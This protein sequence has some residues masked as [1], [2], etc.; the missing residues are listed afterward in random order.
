MS[1]E[2]FELGRE[3]A[4]REISETHSLGFMIFKS[5]P[6]AVATIEEHHTEERDAIQRLQNLIEQEDGYHYSLDEIF[7][8]KVN[9]PEKMLRPYDKTA[10]TEFPANHPVI[11]MNPREH[12]DLCE[13]LKRTA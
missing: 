9:L 12:R 6:G 7:A 3:D 2:D 1:R 10:S 4:F 11:S 8:F 13:P 5:R